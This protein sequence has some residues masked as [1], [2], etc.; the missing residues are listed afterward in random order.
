MKLT[1]LANEFLKFM[2]KT[3]SE[4][5]NRNISFE[6]FQELYPNYDK[7][8]ISDALYLLE[9]DGLVSIFPADNVAY[10]TTLLPTAIRQYEEN[11]LLRKGY[12]CIKEI[13]SWF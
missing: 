7:N 12:S 8:F 13:A 9:A 2:A 11:T 1:A 5:H 10:L 6:Q 4:T 3:Y